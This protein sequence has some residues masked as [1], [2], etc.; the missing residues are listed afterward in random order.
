MAKRPAP[1]DREGPTW[2]LC[3]HITRFINY[4]FSRRLRASRALHDAILAA[5]EGGYNE[6]EIRLAFWVARCIPGEDWLKDN[7]RKSLEP[8]LVLRYQGRL[9]TYTGKPAKRWLDDLLSRASETSPSLIKGTL[10]TLPEDM[11]AGEIELLE[12]MDV[13]RDE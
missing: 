4:A 9:N 7:L 10:N 1:P 13:K 5:Q 2:R 3:E 12:R 6:D 8:H 11:R